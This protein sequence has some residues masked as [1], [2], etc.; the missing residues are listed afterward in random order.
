[1]K[2]V[3]LIGAACVICFFI[4]KHHQQ[5]K[6]SEQQATH[7]IEWGIRSNAKFDGAEVKDVDLTDYEIDDIGLIHAEAELTY[8]LNGKKLCKKVKAFYTGKFGTIV[9]DFD[10]VGDCD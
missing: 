5:T 9:D 4:Y 7:I 1:M 10:V 3:I 6:V 8:E 2:K